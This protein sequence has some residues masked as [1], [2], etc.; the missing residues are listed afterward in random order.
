MQFLP[1]TRPRGSMT[2][3]RF[4]LL[5][6]M[7]FGFSFTPGFAGND[8]WTSSGPLGGRIT[9]L[10]VDPQERNLVYAAVDFRGVMKST[11]SGKTWTEINAGLSSAQVKTLAMDP[12]DRKVLYAGS[13]GLNKSV[14]SGV[15]WGTTGLGNLFPQVI[16]FHPQDSKIVYVGTNGGVFKTA[17]AGRSFQPMNSGLTGLDV[18]ALAID[19]VEPNVLYAGSYPFFPLFRSVDGGATWS[20]SDKFYLGGNILVDPRDHRIVYAGVLKSIDGGES[21]TYAFSN[22]VGTEVAHLLGFALAIDPVDHDTLYL[23]AECSFYRS[24][25]GGG[26]WTPW[27]EGLPGYPD[28]TALALDPADRNTFYVGTAS[29]GVFS[30]TFTKEI[31]AGLRVASPNGAEQWPAGSEQVIYWIHTGDVSDVSIEL[32]TDG[33]ASF[34]PVSTL[35]MPDALQYTWTVPNTPSPDCIIRVRETSGTVA[36]VSDAKFSIVAPLPG[37]FFSFTSPTEGAMVSGVV[38]LQITGVDPSR[39]TYYVDGFAQASIRSGSWDSSQHL[40]GLHR[41]KASVIEGGRFINRQISVTV[42]NPSPRFETMTILPA[43][44]RA[45]GLGGAFYTTDVTVAN[46]GKADAAYSLRFASHDSDGRQ[47]PAKQYLLGAGK[48]VTFVD[49]LNSVFALESDYG[50]IHLLSGNRDLALQ[51]QTSTPGAG[52]TFGQSVPSLGIFQVAQ[53]GGSLL[54]AG[55]R[56]DSAF[57]TNLILASYVSIVQE[58]QVS[59]VSESGEKLA[60]KTYSLAPLSMTQ[61][62]RVVRDLGV[63]GDIASA[64]LILSVKTPA[65]SFGAYASAIDNVTNDPRTLLP[66]SSSSIVKSSARADGAGGAFYTTDLTLLNPDTKAARVA[67]QFLGHDTD[68]RSGPVRRLKIPPGTSVTHRDV[69]KSLFDLD[70]GYGAIRIVPSTF[71]AVQ[72]QTSTPGAGGTFGQS[73]YETTFSGLVKPGLPRHISGVRDDAVFRTNLILTNVLE[74]PV[75]VDIALV[76]SNGQTL[77]TRR[78]SLPP[79]G[80]TQLTRVARELSSGDIIDGRLMLSVAGTA[81]ASVAA[82]ASVIDNV[83]N[84]PRT[85]LPQPASVDP[86]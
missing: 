36:D 51:G 14:D 24:R 49:V 77:G 76:A 1:P 67:I 47:G 75:D 66:A 57:R 84:D 61:V 35:N 22:C 18:R 86:K 19:P 43:S 55:V 40:N 44:A 17:D 10:V 20:A 79:L 52:G 42:N 65:G 68:G 16:A 62:T 69:L 56:E 38:P 33:G 58:V 37:P 60:S 64:R 73:V 46:T 26:F 5:A 41:L 81:P 39:V 50:A 12:R 7:I 54:L 15:T 53:T 25:D 45:S 32:S 13:F 82:Y 48:T 27:F 3:F 78:V 11:D 9:G 2:R 70:S 8:L 80:M 28:L 74:A 71:V 30:I 34:T 63:S 85:L 59:L 23:A 72:T 6:L 31:P 21:W 83:T 4:P 29:Q